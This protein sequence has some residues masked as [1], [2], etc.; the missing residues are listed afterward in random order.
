M[1]NCKTLDLSKNK[2]T[3]IVAEL[4]AGH[5]LPFV[6]TLELES[7]QLNA[8]DQENIGDAIASAKLP[9]LSDLWLSDSENCMTDDQVNQVLEVCVTFF[10]DHR[11]HVHVAVDHF[12]DYVEFEKRFTQRCKG[13]NVWLSWSLGTRAA[14]NRQW[15]TGSV[16]IKVNFTNDD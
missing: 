12:L 11:F 4:L 16:A 13:T 5:G 6:K 2:L 14:I 8:K 3:G 10:A 9:A 15:A 1:Q 7:V